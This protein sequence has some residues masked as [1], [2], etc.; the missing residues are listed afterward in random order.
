MKNLFVFIFSMT[1]ISSFAQD[2]EF[3]SSNFKDDKE[4][5]KT[6]IEQIDNGDK[7]LE[8]GN[9]AVVNVNDTRDHFERAL[10]YYKRAEEFNSNSAE[11]NYKMGNALLYTNE[12]YKAKKYLDKSLKLNPSPEAKFYY[13]YAQAVQLDMEFNKA[14]EFIEKFTTEAKSKRAEELKKF[15]SKFKKE[16]KNAPELINTPIRAWVDNV[17]E[18]NSDKDDFSPCI[19]A[20]GEMLIFTSKRKNSHSANDVGIYDDDIYQSELIKGKWSAPKNIGIPLST[21]GNETASGL[22]YDGQRMLLFSYDEGDAN[23]LES[24]LRGLTWS[25][26]KLKLA[27]NVNTEAN[28][29]YASYE[30]ADIKVFYV[31]DGKLKGDM[32]IYFSGIMDQKRNEWGKGQSVGSQ[33]NTSFNEATVFI[34]PDGRTMYFSSQGHNSIGGYDIYRAEKVQGIWTNPVNLGYPINT[35]Y[36]D[37]FFAYTA[38]EKYAYISSN[39]NGGAGGLD[40]YQVTFWGSEKKIL[41][42]SEDQLIASQTNPIRNIPIEEEIKVEKKSLTV[43]KGKVVDYLTKEPIGADL[44]ITDNKTAEPISN[45]H[46]NSASGKFLLSLP[47]GRNYGISVNKEGYLFHSEN[48][49]Q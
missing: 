33:V 26:P 10:F 47:S 38:N 22:S 7:Y 45:V 15:T 8:L 44:V 46:S 6:A 49:I 12:K 42:D 30:P 19:T 24:E 27:A 4:G 29:T 21:E 14:V 25:E 1:I 39:R 41:F 36:D 28:E 40:I 9:I 32:D 17:K 20:D 11:L 43:F 16:C 37:M 34:H 35:P 5:L 3:K 18:I 13:Y 48:A 2:V 31:Y 23:I